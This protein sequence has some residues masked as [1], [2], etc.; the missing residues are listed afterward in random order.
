MAARDQQA[1]MRVQLAD[2]VAAR[3]EL[4]RDPGAK[5]DSI[6]DEAFVSALDRFDEG[7]T[8][9]RSGVVYRDGTAV[10]RLAGIVRQFGCV[11]RIRLA[12]IGIDHKFAGGDLLLQEWQ[13]DR[14]IAVNCNRGGDAVLEEIGDLLRWT[15]LCDGARLRRS[16][17]KSADDARHRSDRGNVSAHSKRRRRLRISSGVLLD[18]PGMKGGSRRLIFR[19]RALRG[20][21]PDDERL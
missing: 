19:Q 15:G 10:Q 16:R 9:V 20:E 18:R 12:R 2:S 21:G 13:H 17:W 11:E 1:I 7:F 14:F 6:A 4:R 5:I 3:V 8:R